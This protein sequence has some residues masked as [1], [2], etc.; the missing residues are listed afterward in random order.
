MVER[1]SFQQAGGEA[2]FIA[3]GA[4]VGKRVSYSLTAEALMPFI[5]T[6]A[7]AEEEDKSLTE[8]TNIDVT[9]KLSF[10]LVSWASLDYQLRVQRVP[11]IQEDYQIQNT[12]LLTFAFTLLESDIDANE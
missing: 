7:A 2:V 11:Q 6:S 4:L 5:D 3:K 10:K 9:G 12:F 1:S 8:R